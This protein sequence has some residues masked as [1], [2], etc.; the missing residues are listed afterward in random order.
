MNRKVI[1][2]G[3]SGKTGIKICEQLQ[4]SQLTHSAFVRKGSE[5]KITTEDTEFIYGDVL[6]KTDIEDIFKSNDYT[7]IIISLGSKD[8]KK[9]LVR[10]TGTKNIVEVLQKHSTKS[11]IHIVSALGVGDSWDQMNWV[12]KLICKVLIRN[13]M[14]DHNLQEEIV[15]KS[16]LEYHIIRPVELTNGELSGKLHDQKQGFLPWSKISR[17]DVAKY[18]VEAM[19]NN[20]NGFSSICRSNQ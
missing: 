6:N 3:A 17:A 12:G 5:N 9:S 8:L 4:N 7:D 1:V 14:L 10:S 15:T 11:K 19:L 18:L 16:S 20:K 13:T 2:F